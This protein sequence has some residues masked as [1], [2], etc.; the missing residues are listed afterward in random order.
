MINIIY[1]HI[2]LI[3]TFPI[4]QYIERLANMSDDDKNRYNKGLYYIDFQ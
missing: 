3:E 2:Y 1:N 4:D